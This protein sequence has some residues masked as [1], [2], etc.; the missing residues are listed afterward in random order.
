MTSIV[1]LFPERAGAEAAREL[2][3]AAGYEGTEVAVLAPP[4]ALPT[5]GCVTP[6]LLQR[7]ESMLRMGVRW[8]IVGALAA[9]L[10]L[11]ALFLVVSVDS[12]AMVLMLAT[13]WKFGGAFG[14]W[15]GA[16]YGSERG[17]DQ[18]IAEDYE[19]LLT[20]GRW[21]VAADV[22]RRDRFSA[23]GAMVESGA[24]EARDIRGTLEAKPTV[25]WLR[26]Y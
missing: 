18:D 19:E 10:P 1:G 11:V 14:A 13:F 7:G 2:L 23:R 5:A 16:M 15:I 12:T 6:P 17:L 8:G 4:T 26:K 3:G 9:E 21:I 20:A 25:H 22:R 24:L